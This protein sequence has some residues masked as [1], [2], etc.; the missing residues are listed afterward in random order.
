M[1]VVSS[2]PPNRHHKRE[3]CTV[4]GHKVMEGTPQAMGTQGAR[5]EASAVA[6]LFP[7]ALTEL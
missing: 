2:S 6:A 4:A 1:K 3:I 7:V 5:V